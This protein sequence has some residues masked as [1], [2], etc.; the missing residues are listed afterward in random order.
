MKYEKRIPELKYPYAHWQNSNIFLKMLGY[1]RIENINNNKYI[2]INKIFQIILVH[3]NSL[4]IPKI[5]I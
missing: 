3:Y 4:Y 5:L 2:N 1:F